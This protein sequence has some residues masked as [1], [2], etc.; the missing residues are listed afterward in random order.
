MAVIAK[1]GRLYVIGRPLRGTYE[2]GGGVTTCAEG[3]RGIKHTADMAPLTRDVRMRA[4]KLKARAEVIESLL[5][6]RYG[7]RGIGEYHR[8][9]YGEHFQCFHDHLIA[10]TLLNES[11]EWHRPQSVP[12]S[13][14]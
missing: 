3:Q 6:G 8:K 9:K 13:L 12:N 2:R 7:Q 10:S 11:A 1:A 4:V 5:C 14:S